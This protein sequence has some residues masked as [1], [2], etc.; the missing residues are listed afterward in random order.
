MKDLHLPRRR[1]DH[2]IRQTMPSSVQLQEKVSI[3]TQVWFSLTKTYLATIVDP[4]LSNEIMVDSDTLGFYVNVP[5]EY[6]GTSWKQHPTEE[7]NPI[8]V[9]I[10]DH[11]S[12]QGIP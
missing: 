9:D 4:R 5:P 10:L 7:F 2:A 8:F 3:S 12:L 11:H 6:G 1:F